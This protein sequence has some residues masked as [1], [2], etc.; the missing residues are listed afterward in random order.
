MAQYDPGDQ[1]HCAPNHPFG[2]GTGGP[3]NGKI[4]DQIG[5]Y[6]RCYNSLADDAL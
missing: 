5:G 1:L 4:A 2:P 6:T 3:R